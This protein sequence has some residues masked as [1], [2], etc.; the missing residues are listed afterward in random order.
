[1]KYVY[2]ECGI[3]HRSEKSTCI[4]VTSVVMSEKQVA[5]G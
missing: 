2:S 5:K 3:L 4:N 1:M